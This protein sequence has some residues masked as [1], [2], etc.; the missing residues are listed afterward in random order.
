MAIQ[1][2]VISNRPSN[3]NP[4]S[5][6]HGDSKQSDAPDQ[7]KEEPSQKTS[8]ENLIGTP[9]S[10]D[11]SN[12]HILAD[13]AAA[14]SDP[15]TI[16]N[17]QAVQP[18][19]H[20]I[21]VAGTTLTPGAPAI[22]ASG[23]S[24][25]LGS[26]A[27]ILGTSTVPLLFQPSD[28]FITTVAGHRIAA[29]P[30]AVDVA[31]TTLHPGIPG[32]TLDGKAVS[33]DT[34]DHLIIGSKTIALSDGNK[35]L[36][37]LIWGG[38]KY[39]STPGVAEP[40]ITTIAGH[41]ITAAPNAVDVAGTTLHPGDP[42]MTVDGTAVT[43]DTAH[44]LVIGSKTIPL[45]NEGTSLSGLIL[46]G[47]GHPST[48]DDTHPF[49]TTVAGQAITAAPTAVALAGTTLTPGAPG[50]M[51]NGMLVSLN[52]A[53]QLV[54]G[55]KTVALQSEGSG[56]GTGGL[57]FSSSSQGNFS[58]SSYSNGTGNLTDTGDGIKAFKINAAALLKHGL[59]SSLSLLLL[60]SFAVAFIL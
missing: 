56:F 13:G 45:T 2:V 11:P 26:S 24:I 40:F 16:I 39:Q 30:S 58:S 36:D 34:A 4:D 51:I 9:P 41:A 19:S 27:F 38:S 43:L 10:L 52:T 55:S 35:G 20:G 25:S 49:I 46:G 42:G 31:G 60:S 15:V 37:R 28:P 59:Y 50:K 33:L 44:H 53:G 21:S 6:A 47:L 18:L 29:A 1:A 7:A 3:V 54:M 17:N 23:I 48:D 22:T 57:S 12:D 32:V 14:S 5:N 8:P